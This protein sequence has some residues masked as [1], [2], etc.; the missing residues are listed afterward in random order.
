MGS[1]F[2]VSEEASSHILFKNS[3]IG[4]T[5]GDTILTL[6]QLMPVRLIKN[7]FFQE[8]SEAEQRGATVEEL[9]SLLGRGRAKKGMF[10]GNLEEGELEIGQVSAL[11][12]RILPAAT[13]VENIWSEFKQALSMPLRMA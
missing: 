7:K 8:V 11:L 2:V 10:E 4:A 1:R 12:D 6:K 3:V 5:E 13:I 9:K